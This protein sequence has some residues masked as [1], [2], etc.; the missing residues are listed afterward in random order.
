[1]SAS[2]A[3]PPAASL[4]PSE[5]TKRSGSSFLLGFA[6]LNVRASYTRNYAEVIIPGMPAHAVSGGLG[7]A[8]GRASVYSNINWHD[9]RP[10]NTAGTQFTRHRV[11]VDVGGSFRFSNRL[12]MFI[13]IRNLLDEPY[14]HMQD[15]GAAGIALRRYEVPGVNYTLGIKGTF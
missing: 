4:R 8:L 9:N 6:C 5:I 12:S 10:T 7:Y 13:S 11:N 2:I 15:L 1:M 14:N 3:P